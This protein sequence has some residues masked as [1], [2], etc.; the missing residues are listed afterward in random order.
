MKRINTIF[1]SLILIFPFFA[2]AQL[3]V[4]EALGVYGGRINAI[5][6]ISI[7]SDTSRIF[8]S[9]ESANT[10]FWADVYTGVSPSFGDFTVIPGM[11]GSAGYGSWIH[12][13]G[14]H[15]TSGKFFFIHEGTG[16][17]SIEHDGISATNVVLGNPQ[18]FLIQDDYL[19]YL[20]GNDLH[21][22]L[23]DASG[24]YT[25]GT[26]SPVGLG[27]VND[28]ATIAISPASDSVY[29]FVAGITP[30]IYKLSDQYTALSG[31]T[32][33][34]N[35][36]PGGLSTSVFWQAF[37]VGFDGRLCI[38]G[39]TDTE[40]WFAWSDDEIN[41]TEYDT[42][43]GGVSGPNLAFSGNTTSYYVYFA[44][45]YNNNNGTSANDW[46]GFGVIGGDETHPNDGAVF[47]D[48]NNN[49]IC[50]MTTD[51][52]IGASEDNGVTIFEINDG[53]EA[54]Q[55][56]D[57]DMDD[58]KNVA[59]VASKSGVRKV[60]N[61]QTSPVWT[62]PMYPFDDGSPYFS[63]DMNPADTNSAYVGN[64]RIYKT[65][66]GGASWVQ[67]FT[68]ED[69]PYSFSQIGTNATAIEVF[70]GDTNIVFAGFSQWNSDKGGL[71]YSMDAGITWDQLLIEVSSIG[72]DVDVDDIVFNI[73]GTDTVA[74]IGVEYDVTTLQGRSI[75]RI[76]KSGSTWSVAQDMD[77]GG[78]SV[79][80]AITA[81]I[82]DLEVSI[83]GDTIFSCGTDAGNNHPVAYYKPI[84]ATNLWTPFST[85]GFP[86]VAGKQGRAITIGVDTVY[87]A[88]DNEIYIYPT[89]GTSWSTGY[90]YPAGM[91]INVLYW[92]E[93]F[94]GTSTGLYGHYGDGTSGVKENENEKSDFVKVYPNPAKDLTILEFK[95]TEP[96]TI[97]I[98]VVD[99]LGKARYF[100]QEYL[101]NGIHK[102]SLDLSKFENGIYLLQV[103]N[104]EQK[105]II[106]LIVL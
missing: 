106:R 104:D 31:S 91:E 13:I 28:M 63:A 37:G 7:H 24:N 93:L 1:L 54:V 58:T 88:V 43:L 29:V 77:A 65:E 48:P 55:V 79:G 39:S 27:T 8:I 101:R 19:L 9:T 66:D 33:Y 94:V 61:Y 5:T 6:G 26:G 20:E 103:R 57:V 64:V 95:L 100:K 16:I 34:S 25:A 72:Q 11:D 21:F 78:T 60:S 102:I 82:R 81:T 10:A 76:T 38:G 85:S 17:N 71:F 68:P 98:H 47:A 69:P 35:I 87:C 32:T 22:G 75:Y 67:S 90:S 80:Y 92:D 99:L 40:K 53:V 3:T 18:T 4:P 86:F 46:S 62:V 51:M 89:V 70:R 105:Q 83:T 96:E 44:N 52:G 50:Y 30:V 41:W 97:N 14:A 74:Y 12:S 49:A 84:S 42:G 56:E 73:E 45:G 2:I 15:E 59:W 23:L 36:S